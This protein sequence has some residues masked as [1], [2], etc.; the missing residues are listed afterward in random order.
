ME[1]TYDRL[2][3]DFILKCLQ[4]IRFHL[5]WNKWIMEC[6]SSVSYSIIVNGGPN[7]LSTLRGGI[8]QGDSLSP[9]IFILCIEV[10]NH[11]LFKEAM[12]RK[13]WIGVKICPKAMT[14]SCLHFADDC[15]LFC[16]TTSND[17]SKL[18]NILDHF[19]TI[20]GQLINYRKSA[21][22]FSRNASTAQKQVVIGLLHIIR[23]ESLGRYLGCSIFQG[24]PYERTFWEII[25]KATSKL[26]G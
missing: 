13:S 16:K 4:E 19:S 21:P 20:L 3:W 1:K 10:L 26:A 7:G 14:I 17:C 15:L 11:M 25:S 23:R 6:I 5:V 18:K 2:E 12:N 8:R 22:A 24:S 9:Y